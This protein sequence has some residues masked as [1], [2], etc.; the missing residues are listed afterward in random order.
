M[1][2]LQITQKTVQIND[3]NICNEMWIL[4]IIPQDICELTHNTYKALSTA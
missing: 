4:I 1:Q 3:T 2:Q